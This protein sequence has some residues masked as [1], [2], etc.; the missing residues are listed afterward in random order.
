[1]NKIKTKPKEAWR[2]GVHVVLAIYPRP[3]TSCTRDTPVQKADSPH[4]NHP[5]QTTSWL[6]AGLCVYFP[7]PVLGLSMCASCV[8]SHSFCE[9]MYVGIVNLCLGTLN[10]RVFRPA[11]LHTDRIF[12][13]KKGKN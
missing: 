4:R 10:D 13:K 8:S 9:S 5:S 3:G 11:G 1:M 2:C 6:G 7:F 12:K